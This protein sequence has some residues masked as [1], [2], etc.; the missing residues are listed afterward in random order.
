[1]KQVPVGMEAFVQ[2]I[3]NIDRTLDYKTYYG[4]N[5][6]K[7]DILKN[8]QDYQLISLGE[9]SNLDVSVLPEHHKLAVK[10]FR[11]KAFAASMVYNMI[12]FQSEK[13]NVQTGPWANDPDPKIMATIV[14]KNQNISVENAAKLVEF[15]QR[16]MRFL[17]NTIDSLRFDAEL[18]LLNATTTDEVIDQFGLIQVQSMLGT[19]IDLKTVF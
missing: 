13:H 14:A 4:T 7:I 6:E 19:S 5:P 9:H 16:E 11:A 3:P 18:R 8:F 12:K 17:S 2:Y 10:L 15:K 1:M